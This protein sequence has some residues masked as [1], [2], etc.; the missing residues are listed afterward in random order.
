MTS[1]EP[2]KNI[3]SAKLSLTN[4]VGPVKPPA[5]IADKWGP[6]LDGL[7]NFLNALLKFAIVV[8][9]L[10]ALVNLILAGYAFMSAGDDPK[11]IA[12]ATSKIWQSI[13]GLAI[14]A[15]SFVLAAIFGKLL[16]NDWNALLQLQVWGPGDL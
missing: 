7:S 12:G 15:G 16:F 8:A 14:A 9:G 4:P 2:I 1:I 6:T 10:F 3:S 5:A 11:K 13:L